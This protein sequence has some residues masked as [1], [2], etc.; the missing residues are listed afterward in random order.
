MMTIAGTRSQVASLLW[1]NPLAVYRRLRERGVGIVAVMVLGLALLCAWHRYDVYAES[2]EFIRRQPADSQ[3][4]WR[5]VGLCEGMFATQESREYTSEKLL[6]PMDGPTPSE[7]FT[8]LLQVSL[9]IA[10]FLAF[11]IT[12]SKFRRI[13]KRFVTR[14]FSEEARALPLSPG[15]MWLAM[16]DYRFVLASAVLLVA[17]LSFL[18]PARNVISVWD[19]SRRALPPLHFHWYVIMLLLNG[20]TAGFAVTTMAQW[21]WYRGFSPTRNPW[22]LPLAVSVA[23]AAMGLVFLYLAQGGRIVFSYL[24]LAVL[25]AGWLVLMVETARIKLRMIR[26]CFAGD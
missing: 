9:A 4:T 18:L 14:Q 10:G 22:L 7:Q 21:F 19:A 5:K 6:V 8:L 2:T 15:Q 1:E 12:P 11:Q 17:V 16:V 3:Q 20:W 24:G 26:E 13:R 25:Q 23:L